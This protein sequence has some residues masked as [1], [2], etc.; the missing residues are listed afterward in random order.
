MFLRTLVPKATETDVDTFAKK[1]IDI[2]ISLKDAMV[3][4]Q[5]IYRCYFFD[6]GVAFDSGWMKVA[7]GAAEKGKVKLSTFPGLRRF[8][9]TDG[10]RQ[11][12]PVVKAS[13]DLE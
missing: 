7:P 4:E 12:V 11:F 13:T 10:R 9:M 3:K 2:S 1:L 6:N 5:A 8:N